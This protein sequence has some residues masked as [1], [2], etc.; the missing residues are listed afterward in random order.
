MRVCKHAHELVKLIRSVHGDRQIFGVEVGVADGRTSA[1]LL[2]CLP[3]L[4]LAMID[5]STC[6]YG[7]TSYRR[8]AY[9][10]DTTTEI[11]KPP[12]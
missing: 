9:L 3:S 10:R 1:F 6:S 7:G 4:S 11:E 12:A 5:P 8:E 2:D